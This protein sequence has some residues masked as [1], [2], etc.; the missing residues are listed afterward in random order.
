MSVYNYID[1]QAGEHSALDVK[2][3]RKVRSDKSIPRGSYK[4]KV[5]NG[6]VE[7]SPSVTNIKS[8]ER[9][10][11]HDVKKPRKV[12]SDKSVPRGP[13]KMKVKNGE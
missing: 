5:K 3:P 9:E 4:M 13:Y 2:K 11:N 1:T 8:Y 12:R 10:Y 7:T 6:A